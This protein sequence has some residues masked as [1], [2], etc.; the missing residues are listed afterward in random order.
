M[1]ALDLLDLACNLTFDAEK[2]STQMITFLVKLCMLCST[3]KS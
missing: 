2:R 1:L 3:E